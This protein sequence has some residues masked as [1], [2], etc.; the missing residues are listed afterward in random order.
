VL[1][2]RRLAAEAGGHGGMQVGPVG[3][4]VLQNA[5]CSVAI[6]PVG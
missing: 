4:S 5:A 6:V 3:R 2:A 1:G